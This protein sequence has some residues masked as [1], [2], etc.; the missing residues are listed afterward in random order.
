MFGGNAL[1]GTREGHAVD[2][3]HHRRTDHTAVEQFAGLQ[4]LR[5]GVP[6]HGRFAAAYRDQI[7]G[8]AAF[9]QPE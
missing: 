2:D 7:G 4:P 8:G 1:P 9:F 3:R 6:L 5:I